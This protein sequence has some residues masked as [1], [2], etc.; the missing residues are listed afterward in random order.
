MYYLVAAVSR[1]KPDPMGHGDYHFYRQMSDGAWWHKSGEQLPRN[2]D[3]LG[4]VI[5]NP[6]TANR[7]YY[8]IFVGYYYVPENGLPVGFVKTTTLDMDGPLPPDVLASWKVVQESRW[9][10][11]QTAP[12]TPEQWSALNDFRRLGVEWTTTSP[13]D[14]ELPPLP[15]LPPPPPPPRRPS[16]RQP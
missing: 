10:L 6:M 3:S 2:T 8:D 14:P 5:A 7:G 11:F 16:S 13:P 15:P 1:S 9:K 12:Y 4:H